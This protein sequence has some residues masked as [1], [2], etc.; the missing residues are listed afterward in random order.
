M[1]DPAGGSHPLP[2]VLVHGAWHGAW[3]YAALQAELDR[4]GVP[5]FAVDLPG[6]GASTAP[7]GDLHGDADHVV[8]VLDAV[9]P[10]RQVVLVGHSYGGAVVTHAAARRPGAVAHLVYLAAFAPGDGES[11]MDVLTAAPSRD[12]ALLGAVVPGDDGTSTVD[13]AGAVAAFYGSCPPEAA[14][15]ATA[16]LDRHPAA[17]FTQPVA[18]DPRATIGSTYVVCLRDQAVHPDH[19]R[20]MAARCGHVVEIDTDHSPF[21]STPGAVAD[22][23]APIAGQAGAA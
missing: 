3:C 20:L 8:A 2:V 14:A 12:V 5:S 9:A 7:L 23:L 18:G 15:A 16:R 19:Q 21:L 11:L 6:H 10:G 13:P 17:T 22:V 4:R 1:P